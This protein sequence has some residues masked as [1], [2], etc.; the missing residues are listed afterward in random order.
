M[1]KTKAFRFKKVRKPSVERIPS[2][3]SIQPEEGEVLLGQLMGKEA[4]APEER[5]GKALQKAGI[6]FMFRYVM[7]APKGLPG[8]KEIDFLVPVNGLVYAVEV[9]TAFTH[10]SKGQKDKLHDALI[11]QD[12]GVQ[13]MGTLWPTVFHA[14]GDSELADSP[15]AEQYVKRNFGR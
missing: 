5:L 9:D 6:N 14:D 11:L 4:S 8:W 3:V 1:R 2:H 13:E 10:R 15:N 7:G 12:K